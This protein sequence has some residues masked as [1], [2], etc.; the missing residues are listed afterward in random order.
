MNDAIVLF[1]G[2]CNFCN[3]SVNF[4]IARDKKKYFR[5]SPIQS[6]TGQKLIRQYHL[7]DI[8]LQSIILIENNKA[9]IYSTAMLKVVR[10]ING[11]WQLAYLFILVPPV[12]RDAIYKIIA[13][14]RY[15]WFGKKEQ[16]KVPPPD[17]KS[18]FIMD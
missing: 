8:N 2:V 11:L 15:K 5:F 18:R 6:V 10:K 12:I 1:D 13:R 7:E 16:C 9:Y 3:S 14:N 4:I 17:V